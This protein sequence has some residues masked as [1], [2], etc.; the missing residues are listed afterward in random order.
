MMNQV[1][2]QEVQQHLLELLA[3]LSPGEELQIVAGKKVIG[4]LI[5]EKDSLRLPRHPGS[6][7]GSLTI[8]AEDD[9]YLKDFKA[10]PGPG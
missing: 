9:D 5:A 8:V 7:I 6:A 3:D 4:R 2:A 10:L 1:T